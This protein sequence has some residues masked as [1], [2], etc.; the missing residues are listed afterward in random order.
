MNKALK[1][2]FI[3]ALLISFQSQSYACWDDDDDDYY[4]YWDDDD[5]DDYDWYDY[6]WYDY[7]W[8]DY[9]WDDYDDG[10]IW[11]DEVC[12][13]GE[14]PDNDWDDWSGFT[15]DWDD[16]NDWDD[17]DEEY[18]GDTDSNSNSNKN[19]TVSV[20]GKN[21]DNQSKNKKYVIKNTDKTSVD[22]DK[23]RAIEGQKQGTANT[24]VLEGMSICCMLFGVTMT[25]S[26]ALNAMFQIAIKTDPENALA[27][28]DGNYQSDRLSNDIISI[29]TD[30]GMSAHEI[31]NVDDI[32]EALNNGEVVMTVEKI[33][34][35]SNHDIVIVGERSDGSGYIAYDTDRDAGYYTTITDDQINPVYIIGIKKQ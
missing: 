21:S 10:S 32:K 33:T 11:L 6:D 8:Y 9:D 24:C 3:L 14:A 22:K 17:W 2:F 30:H 5:W 26:E 1:L 4:G 28:L 15:D 20:N 27:I 23:L 12:C 19:S 16:W 25:E 35:D 31:S 34:E 7:D 13:Y 18:D 29:L